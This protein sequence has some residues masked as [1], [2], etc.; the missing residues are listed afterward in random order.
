MAAVAPLLE[1]L[2]LEG[3]VHLDLE[4]PALYLIGAQ[5]MTFAACHECRFV[6]TIPS[7]PRR[8]L[9][10]WT[11]PNGHTYRL[12]PPIPVLLVGISPTTPARA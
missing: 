5:P 6:A 10:T 9:L 7:V 3:D 4:G 2:R 11:C 1:Q 12:A 8:Q